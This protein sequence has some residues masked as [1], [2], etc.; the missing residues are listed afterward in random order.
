MKKLIILTLIVVSTLMLTGCED[1]SNVVREIDYSEFEEKID[2]KDSFIL[3][4]IQTG[5]SHCEEFSPRFKAVLKTNNLEAF[6]IN[7]YNLTDKEL[8]KFDKLM[9]ISGTPTVVFFEDGEESGRFSG[10]VSNE[11]LKEELKDAGYIE[12]E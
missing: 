3:E 11:K 6:S 10:A 5:C 4:V 7:I 2:N 12:I 8:E 1:D 9:T